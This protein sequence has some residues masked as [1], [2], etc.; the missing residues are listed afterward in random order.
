MHRR[1]HNNMGFDDFLNTYNNPQDANDF[2]SRTIDNYNNTNYMSSK[3]GSPSNTSFDTPNASKQVPN[4]DS[5]NRN[6]G[7]NA[8]ET[9]AKN[10]N[11]GALTNPSTTSYS[12]NNVP[13][14]SASTDILPQATGALP[15]AMG[16][17]SPIETTSTMTDA[18]AVGNATKW[19]DQVD[20]GNVLGAG[21]MVGSSLMASKNLDDSIDDINEGLEGIKGM[22]STQNIDTLNEIDSIEQNARNTIDASAD[23]ANLRL[24]QALDNINQSNIS[25]G[26]VRRMGNEIRKKL[27]R[28]LDATAKNVLAKSE[29]AIDRVNVS[30][31]ASI[32]KIRG[33]QEQLKAK[34][35]QAQK[36][37]RMAQWG[38]A[39]GV[40][41]LISDVFVPGSGQVLRSGFN[42][43]SRYS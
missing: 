15:E 9:V 29:S 10:L 38:T 6:V 27:D 8:K 22:V 39:V 4:L 13:A 12:T 18:T 7:M 40:G 26:A 36:D 5:Q 2:L 20:I 33:L 17:Q 19:T 37:K 3:I 31:R 1:G 30:N 25:T 28:N 43:Y 34:K 24:G 23:S 42:T 14:P 21:M 16:G 41:S 32:D 35:K 11:A